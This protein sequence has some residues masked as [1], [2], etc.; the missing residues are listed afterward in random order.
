MNDQ[1]KKYIED[2]RDDFDHLEPSPAVFLNLKNQIKQQPKQKKGL[3][4]LIVNHKWLAA[5]CVL[6][7][8]SIS[9][10]LLNNNEKVNNTQLAKNKI[11]EAESTPKTQQNLENEKIVPIIKSEEKTAK[12]KLKKPVRAHHKSVD[13]STIY[14]ELADSSS[15]STRL[16]AVLKIQKSEVMSYDIIDNLAK[17]LNNDANSNVR[18][19]AFNLMSHYRQDNYVSSLFLQSLEKQKDPLL[20]LGLID[21]LK[22][23]NSPKLDERLY[24]L[25][26]DPNTLSEVKDQAYLVLLNQ[27]K[28]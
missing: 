16:A 7:V 1:L 3:M 23:F 4:T 28:L 18:L 10:L 20:Q 15:A 9:Y 5:A 8:F 11:T 26:N 6:I 14:R 22:Q 17:T 2:N 12:T 27:N 25:A 21:M 19:A 13:M 24:A